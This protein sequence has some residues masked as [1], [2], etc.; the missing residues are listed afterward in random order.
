M[1]QE[2]MNEATALT[3]IHNIANNTENINNNIMKLSDTITDLDLHIT[4]LD[5]YLVID[6]IEKEKKE[7]EQNTKEVIEENTKK[8][9]EADN[10]STTET[11][12]SLEDVY[13]EMLI[14]NQHLETQNTLLTVSNFTLGIIVG[15]ILISMFWQRFFK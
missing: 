1:A 3:D 13:Q 14:T 4:S 10:T 2:V 8:D 11:N 12:I 7:N 6:K 9:G 15:A 5:Q